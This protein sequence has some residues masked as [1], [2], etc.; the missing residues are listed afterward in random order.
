[1]IGFLN[2]KKVGYLI[3]HLAMDELYELSS[4]VFGVLKLAPEQGKSAET[5][6]GNNLNDCRFFL[7]LAIILHSCSVSLSA[8]SWRVCLLSRFSRGDHNTSAG[9][10]ALGLHTQRKL[11][12]LRLTSLQRGRFF[13]QLIHFHFYISGFAKRSQSCDATGVKTMSRGSFKSAE[14]IF[15]RFEWR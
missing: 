12:V 2:S 13:V 3:C 7:P 6:E 1:M 10:L 15:R 14:S 11:K 5:E 8:A 4:D 9:A